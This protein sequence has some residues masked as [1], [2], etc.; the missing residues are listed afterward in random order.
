MFRFSR[1]FPLA[2]VAVALLVIACGG[3]DSNDGAGG[4]PGGSRG[5]GPSGSPWAGQGGGDAIAAVPVVSGRIW[6]LLHRRL[7]RSS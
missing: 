5:G 4:R 7:R 3:G 2:G 6:I 1:L